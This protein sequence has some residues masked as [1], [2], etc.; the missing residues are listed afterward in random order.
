EAASA[1]G[2]R[3]LGDIWAMTRAVA[4][5]N[6]DAFF[7]PS[8]YTYF[9]TLTDATVILGV[10]DV[11]AEDYPQLIFPDKK[12]R[13]LWELKGWFAH[14]QADYI[15]TVSEHAKNGIIR[16]FG[17]APDKVF[18]IDE[19][20]D[21]I[22]RPLPAAE[23]DQELF[24]KFGMSVKDRFLLYLGGINPHKNLLTLAQCF[25]RARQDERFKD[26]KLAIIGDI[27]K[28]GF[29]PGLNELRQ[30]IDQL[31]V[32]DSV[33]FTGF[34][35]DQDAVHFLN[36]AQAVVL[37][38]YAEGFGLPA[39]EG[40]ACGTPVVA[41]RNS[42]LPD[43]LAGGGMFI[44]PEKPD[45]LLDAIIQLLSDDV[46]RRN[47]GQVAKQKAQK[48]TW[49]HSANQMQSMLSTVEESRS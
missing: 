39:I 38:S 27:S 23:L 1:S 35:N 21:P 4:K 24:T 17:H 18:V 40:A 14:K 2:R 13:K 25:A 6:L 12:R 10:H 45:Q 49:Q 11:I 42:P 37:P 19:A 20:A 7:F 22:F 29:T 5:C 16:H 32:K 34:I 36:V 44:D 26:L 31:G 43:L 33:V 47:M 28:D 15:L 46:E 30:T 8:V 41:T 9:P 48:L 3:S